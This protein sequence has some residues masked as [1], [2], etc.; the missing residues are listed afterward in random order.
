MTMVWELSPVDMPHE[1]HEKHLCHLR[2]VGFMSR[3]FEDYKTLVKEANFVCKSCG[4]TATNKES[5]CEPEKL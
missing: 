3:N 2:N 5:L 4:R 1:G